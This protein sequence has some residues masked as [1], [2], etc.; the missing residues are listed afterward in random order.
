MMKNLIETITLEIG[1]W[2]DDALSSKRD[3]GLSIEKLKREVDELYE[4]Y[5]KQMVKDETKRSMKLVWKELADVTILTLDI[6]YL[7]NVNLF[8]EIMEKHLINKHSRTFSYDEK[9]NTHQHD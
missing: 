7:A 2:A 6:T 4:E 1:S 3:V 9:T 8:S 5:H